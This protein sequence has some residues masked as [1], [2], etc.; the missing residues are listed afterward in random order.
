MICHNCGGALVEVMTDLPF[1]IG[2]HAIVVIKNL[3]VLQCG[4]CQEY[5]LEDRVVQRVDDILHS[6]D[7]HL[8]VVILSY[9]A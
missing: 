9:A 4:N 2:L 8:E 1:K 3:P 5:L 7:D 6:A